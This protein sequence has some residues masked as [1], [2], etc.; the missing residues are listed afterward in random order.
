MSQMYSSAAKWYFV[1]LR[2][3]KWALF[4]FKK[5][6]TVKLFFRWIILSLLSLTL[7]RDDE[8]WFFRPV[9]PLQMLMYLVSASWDLAFWHLALTDPYGGDIMCSV[10]TPSASSCYMNPLERSYLR[11][12]ARF[13]NIK[14]PIFVKCRK[15]LHNCSDLIKL[16]DLSTGCTPWL[17]TFNIRR[18]SW[19]PI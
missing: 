15:Y 1:L 14:L 6:R 9:I 7:F 8:W 16:R 13:D 4:S 5:G 19:N 2:W 11:R 12:R 18:G 10:C 17:W 3:G